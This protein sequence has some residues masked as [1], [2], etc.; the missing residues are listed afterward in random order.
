MPGQIGN[1]GGGRKT[2]RAE[3]A[4][5]AALDASLP[6]AVKLCVRFID[7]AEKFGKLKGGISAIGRKE[8]NDLALQAAKILMSKAPQRTELTVD[9]LVPSSDEKKK[10][11]ILFEGII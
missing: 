9:S 10:I 2:V 3:K 4:F 8:I 5:F 11:G 1:K 7:E 6:K